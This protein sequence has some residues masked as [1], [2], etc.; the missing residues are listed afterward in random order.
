MAAIAISTKPSTVMVQAAT[1][2]T[3]NPTGQIP[4][5]SISTVKEGSSS[6]LGS[7]F[8]SHTAARSGA[9]RGFFRENGGTVPA[10]SG[11]KAV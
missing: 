11:L 5:K 1:L 3:G 9:K 6:I 2:G 8:K 10:S 7:G 4:T